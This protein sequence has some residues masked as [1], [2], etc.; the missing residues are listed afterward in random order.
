MASAQAGEQGE[1][2]DRRV[3]IQDGI[4]QARRAGEALRD[5]LRVRLGGSE[6]VR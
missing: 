1:E 6:R 2:G 5:L 4:N 3:E